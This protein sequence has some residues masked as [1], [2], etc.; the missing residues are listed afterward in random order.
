M[1]KYV[2]ISDSDRSTPLPPNHNDVDRERHIARSAGGWEIRDA[3]RAG[4]PRISELS[5]SCELS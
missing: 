4:S 2:V 5:M 1:S 3:F